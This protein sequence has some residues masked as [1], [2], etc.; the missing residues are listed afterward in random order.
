M[1]SVNWVNQICSGDLIYTL[2]YSFGTKS[3]DVE[4]EGV[5]STAQTSAMKALIKNPQFLKD[6]YIQRKVYKNITESINHAKI[7]KIWIRGNYQFMIADPLAQC[8]SALGLEPTGL[9][10]RDEI[11][12]DFWKT[13]KP[14]GC[15]VDCC[16]SPMIDQHEHNPM[17]VIADNEDANYWYRFIKSGIIYNTYDTSCFRHS[18]SD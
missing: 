16:R 9:L 2:L 14:Q 1:P 8:Q 3:D 7:G 15:V 4:Y 13:R 18:D 17:T 11:Y 10:K 6:S 12:S 5:Y